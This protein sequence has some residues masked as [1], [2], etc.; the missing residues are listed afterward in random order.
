MLKA[1]DL[2]RLRTVVSFIDWSLH[3]P[4]WGIYFALALGDHQLRDS[5]LEETGKS[6]LHI[7]AHFGT[8]SETQRCGLHGSN[9]AEQSR[10]VIRL[11][12]EAQRREAR[13]N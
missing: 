13:L 7:P 5:G 11:R 4:V 12:I 10:G 8:E 3:T 1:L 2:A 6:E 9:L